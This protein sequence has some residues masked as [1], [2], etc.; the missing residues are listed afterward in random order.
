MLYLKMI[1]DWMRGLQCWRAA[2][3]ERTRRVD[4]VAD[5]FAGA[6]QYTAEDA[7]AGEAPGFT[8]A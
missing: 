6:T 1:V 3:R 2:V 5:L 8:D 4:V 7:G